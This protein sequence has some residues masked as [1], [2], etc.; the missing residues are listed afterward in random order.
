MKILLSILVL[1]VFA[2]QSEAGENID[3]KRNVDG[4]SI[5]DPGI[6]NF[7]YLKTG[8]CDEQDLNDSNGPDLFFENTAPDIHSPIYKVKNVPVF[9]SLFFTD[10]FQY[11]LIDLP[12]PS[13]SQV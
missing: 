12:P 3:K 11:F 7:V 2:F 1:L 10:S 6:Q 4:I 9:L 8:F 5:F 13:F